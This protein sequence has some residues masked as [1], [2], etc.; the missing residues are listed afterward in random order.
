M[1]ASSGFFLRI[2]PTE[3][4]ADNPP[5]RIQGSAHV[6]QSRQGGGGVYPLS[7]HTLVT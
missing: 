4:P 5:E 7:S 1:S 6:A 2:K 3:G